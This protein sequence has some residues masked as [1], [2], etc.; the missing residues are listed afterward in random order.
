MAASFIA[1]MGFIICKFLFYCEIG[2]QSVLQISLCGEIVVHSLRSG[3]TGLG[4]GELCVVQV[5]K[6]VLAHIVGLGGDVVGLGG[7]LDGALG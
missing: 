7:G 3:K 4:Q 2:S 1:K 5:G 6:S